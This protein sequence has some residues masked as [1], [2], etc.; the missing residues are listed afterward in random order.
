MTER[1]ANNGVGDTTA[2]AALAARTTAA[3]MM[4][5]RAMAAAK[6]V[7]TSNNNDESRKDI[8]HRFLWQIHDHGGY[9]ADYP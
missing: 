9:L 8:Q 1:A 5:A 6:A 4:E 2:N 3:A 7:M